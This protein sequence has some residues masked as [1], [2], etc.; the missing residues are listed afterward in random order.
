MRR[1]QSVE[2]ILLLENGALPDKTLAPQLEV[3]GYRVQRLD[4][5]VGSSRL[6][7]DERPDVII[8]NTRSTQETA[9][10]VIEALGRDP[11][12][13]MVPVI[14]VVEGDSLERICAAMNAGADDCISSPIVWDHLL[15]VLRAR[16]RLSHH[17]LERYQDRLAL[18][19]SKLAETISHEVFVP[20]FEIEARSEYLARAEAALSPDESRAIATDIFEASQT[21]HRMLGKVKLSNALP[22]ND[23]LEAHSLFEGLTLSVSPVVRQTAEMT[24][25]RHGR[26]DDLE[27]EIS[28]ATVSIPIVD[29]TRIVEELVDTAMSLS[30][31]GTPVHVSGRG[32]DE[33]V[34]SVRCRLRRTD[35]G[36]AVMASDETNRSM[37]D[38]EDL[39]SVTGLHIS[40]EIVHRLVAF[41]RGALEMA[42]TAADEFYASVRLPLAA[43]ENSHAA[44]VTANA[45]AFL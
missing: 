9:G 3:E 25:H 35:N 6:P 4:V 22:Y 1:S 15:A 33:F 39:L 21:L 38:L 45:E 36:L 10:A 43:V 32:E 42:V 26:E 18:A 17:V 16:L 28:S 29:L 8:L 5:D 12:T 14:Q 24:A 31:T 44:P 13:A 20:L 11:A 27:F 40:R 7:V 34:L 23:G 41:H 19:R 37:D 30:S 2:R